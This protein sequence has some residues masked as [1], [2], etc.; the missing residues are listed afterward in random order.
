MVKR[1]VD[2]FMTLTFDPIDPKIES[3]GPRIITNHPTKCHAIRFNTFCV[4]RVKRIQIHKYINTR[5]SKHNLTHFQCEGNEKKTS[6]H[7]VHKVV[8][9]TVLGTV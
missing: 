2:L 3:D 4:M 9:F 6:K 1:N 7:T 5:R 8:E